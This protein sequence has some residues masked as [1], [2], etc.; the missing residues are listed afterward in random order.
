MFLGH[1]IATAVGVGHREPL[2][3]ATRPTYAIPSASASAGQRV[4][5]GRAAGLEDALGVGASGHV[6]SLG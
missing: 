2:A 6:V 3:A 1:A 4:A 5:D